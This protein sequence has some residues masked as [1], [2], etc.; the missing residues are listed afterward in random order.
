MAHR[1][2]AL[3]ARVTR[4]EAARAARVA[5]ALGITRSELIR[6]LLSA[7]IELAKGAARARAAGADYTLAVYTGDT[8][9][10]L[11]RMIRK[12]GYQ[13]NQVAHALNAL[14]LRRSMP[15]RV[16]EEEL[17]PALARIEELREGMVGISAQWDRTARE[18]RESPSIAIEGGGRR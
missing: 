12:H 6:A 16:V 11:T 15:A 5:H 3:H 8:I 13:Y 9:D 1:T 4:D 14:M 18:L 10:A 2:T 7:D 17:R